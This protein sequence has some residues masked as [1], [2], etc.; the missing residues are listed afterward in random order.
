MQSY[1]SSIQ[2]LL[3]FS[4]GI[5]TKYYR[6][7]WKLKQL[8]NLNLIY[9]DIKDDIFPLV[10]LFRRI[11]AAGIGIET[12]SNLIKK[13]NYDLPAIE[14]EYKKI[15]IEVDSLEFKKSKKY[16]TL[17]NIE[18][19]IT[20]A[21]RLLK[22]LHMSCQEE[23]AKIDQL[24]WERIKLRRLVKHFKDNDEEYL[25]IKKTVEQEVTRLLLDGRDLLRLAFHSLMELIRKEPDKYSS[26]IYC[27]SASSI[28]SYGTVLSGGP[29]TYGQ[30]LQYP[31]YDSFFEAYKTTLLNE[32]EKLYKK[33]VREMTNGII[34]NYVSKG[35]FYS[36]SVIEVN[37]K[38][39]VSEVSLKNDD[40]EQLNQ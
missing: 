25:K 26:L 8:N 6:E 37:N 32:A 13:A 27:N 2:T 18:D 38:H 4:S 21:I 20:V 12:A 5:V 34:S 33:L 36:S 29:Y 10:K 28:T 15:K 3:R 7:Y 1:D 40:K 35:D 39:K 9:E 14:Q 24:E 11:K 30:Q 22:S 19:Q 23:T 31:S 17:H 16:R